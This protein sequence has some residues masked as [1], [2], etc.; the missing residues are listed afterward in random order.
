MIKANSYSQ[1]ST[2]RMN[3]YVIGWHSVRRVEYN[4]SL[5]SFRIAVRADGGRK[6]GTWKG[7]A[8]DLKG[9]FQ[10]WSWMEDPLRRLYNKKYQLYT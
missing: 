7:E 2:K 4:D 6:V 10:S 8:L 1:Q 9:T 3:L 5:T